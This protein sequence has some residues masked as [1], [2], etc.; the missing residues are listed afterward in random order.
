MNFDW[1]S[2]KVFYW[3]NLR[4]YQSLP[5]QELAIS[6]LLFIVLTAFIV[7]IKNRD[8]LRLWLIKAFVTLVVMIAYEYVYGLDSYLYYADAVYYNEERRVW[9]SSGTDNI[10]IINHFFTYLVGNS[11]YSLK[12]FNSFLGF[13]GLIY[14]YKSFLY[15]AQR[16]GYHVDNKVYINVFFLFPSIIFWSSILGK[17]PLNLLFVG[18]FTYSFLHLM[19]RVNAIYILLIAFSIIGVYYIRSWWA[20]IMVASIVFYNVK[21]NSPKHVLGLAFISPFIIIGL[22]A[23]LSKQGITSFQGIFEKMSDTSENLAYG[24]SSVGVAAITGI[25]DYL[26]LFI[27]NLFTS[28]YRPMP[29]DVRNAFTLLAAIENV[30][31]LYFSFRYIFLEWKNIYSNRYLK[32]FVLFI[33]SWSLFYV[34]ISPTNLGMAARFKLQV[35]PAMLT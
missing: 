15:V 2:I 14:L 21:L 33:F 27:P 23:F 13:I 3:V 4:G 34:I 16:S 18:L 8:Y 29:F 1:L 12:L 6:L 11:Y 17:D 25:T 28:L 10:K 19:D 26:L 9:G 30:V 24:G 7:L 22:G 35:L 20:V 32:F 31:L 5:Y